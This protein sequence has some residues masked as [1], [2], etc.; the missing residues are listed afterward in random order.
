MNKNIAPVISNPK[1]SAINTVAS[2]FDGF[3]V[4]GKGPYFG[5]F[6]GSVESDGFIEN[7]DK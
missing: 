4:D 7:P 1:A 2:T 3:R 6:G 5:T